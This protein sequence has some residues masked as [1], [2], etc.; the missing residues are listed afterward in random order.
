MFGLNPIFTTD[1]YKASHFLQYPPGTQYVTSYVEPRHN[2]TG[3]VDEVVFFGLQA[4]LRNLQAV[5]H[6]DVDAA[7]QF[8]SDHGVSFNENGWRR[9]VDVH[10]G[11]LPIKIEALPEGT[12]HG[13][14]VPQVQVQNTDPEFPWLTS[15]VETALLRAVWYPSTVASV[16]RSVKKTIVEYLEK[17]CDALD[18]KNT[19]LPF[20]LH[21]FGARGASSSETAMLG[22]MAHLVNFM[23][24]DTVEGVL[25]AR[26]YYDEPMAAFSIPASEHSTITS[27][28]PDHELDAHTNMLDQFLKPGSLVA[29][30]SDS[31][32]LFRCLSEY[33]G[34]A[35]RDRIVNS[36]GTVVVRP[37]SG[38]PAEIVL[39]TLEILGD[40][41]GFTVNSKGFRVLHPSIRVIQ[42][43]GVNPD[44]IKRILFN[45]Y[46]KGWS[47]ENVAFGM[48]GALLR[49]VNRDTLGYAMKAN[50]VVIDGEDR[51][52]SKNPKTDP[53]KAS[54][55]GQ[56]AVARVNDVLT[57]VP[58]NE[59][60]GRVNYLRVVY[61]NGTIMNETT[62][63]EVRSRAAV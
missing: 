21:D 26:R 6:Y 27:W 45:M 8:F 42:G 19:I 52:V 29:S 5:S 47:A 63:A 34:G 36:G 13:F 11:R 4:Y 38:D 37:D 1:S 62:F 17:T 46:L 49:G 57:A 58:L 44:S 2:K 9:I 59:L 56:Q 35:L 51:P 50:S 24:S 32:D 23:G 43:D 60:G 33:W 16:S 25:G 14:G 18:W 20:R 61:R 54:K 28:G 53:G 41:F 55:S 40:K 22:G 12:V 31:Y 39:K 15:Y 7:K 3:N 48:G 30:V 10:G